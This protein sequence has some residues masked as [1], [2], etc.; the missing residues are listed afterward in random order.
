MKIEKMTITPAIAADFLKRN[1]KNRP[2]AENR[3]WS[4]A[5]AIKNGE[6][7]MNGDAIRFNESGELIDGQTRLS[8]IILAGIAVDSLV[9][10]DLKDDVFSTID[11]NGSARTASD[12]LSIS[13]MKYYKLCATIALAALSWEK[14]KSSFLASSAKR[15]NQI[16]TTEIADRARNDDLIQII[17]EEYSLSKQFRKLV[18]G[19]IFGYVRYATMRFDREKSNSFFEKLETGANLEPDSP[20]LLL[21]DYLARE[22]STRGVELASLP[23]A[24]MFLSFDLYCSGRSVKQLKIWTDGKSKNIHKYQGLDYMDKIDINV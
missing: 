24:H 13:G 15:N 2:L 14:T 17:A 7:R 6:W 11:I 22:K 23:V 1:T 21:R 16:T 12:V 20:V 19:R 5:N 4:I 3:S 9:I 18:S 10:F 8:A